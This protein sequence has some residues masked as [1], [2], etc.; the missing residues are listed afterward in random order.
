[1]TDHD[2]AL[3]LLKAAF[4]ECSEATAGMVHAM[5]EQDQTQSVSLR[6]RDARAQ[7]NGERRSIK[8]AMDE[9]VTRANKRA[10]P[11]DPKHCSSASTGGASSSSVSS[12]FAAAASSSA[13]SSASSNSS[14]AS[15]SETKNGFG[16]D[17]DAG[18]PQVLGVPHGFFKV[19]IGADQASYDNIYTALGNAFSEKDTTREWSRLKKAAG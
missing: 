18:K 5:E 7:E 1:M 13:S 6:G 14:F 2:D 9:G 19:L 11:D 8:T 10:R 16:A 17:L 12:S 15:A 3:A 4:A